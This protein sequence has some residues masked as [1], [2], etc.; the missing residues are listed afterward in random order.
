MSY[1][2][3]EISNY[4]GA[5][6]HL[7]E[8]SLGPA[9]WRYT[10]SQAPITRQGVT[11]L[12]VPIKH[13][14]I[15]LSGDTKQDDLSVNIASSAEVVTIYSGTP[16]SSSVSLTIREAHRGD[17]DAVVIWSGIIKSV[18][19]TSAAEYEFTCNSLM[20]TLNRNGLRLTWDRAC[21]HALYDRS[22]RVNQVDFAVTA[23]IGTLTGGVIRSPVFATFANGWFAGGF[24]TFSTQFGNLERRGIEA[25]AANVLTLLGTTDGMSVGQFVTAYPGCNRVIS[26]CVNKFN[27]LPNYGGFPHLPNKSP[28]DGD[29]VF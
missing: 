4:G 14:E 11:Y 7:Y 1:D 26:T 29:P 28:F 19:R 5:P 2:D 23:Q 27:N 6:Y 10:D 9:R 15:S 22:C 24:V 25:H 18:R 3:R 8:F 17:P 21:P 13:G 20:S 12:A 16:P